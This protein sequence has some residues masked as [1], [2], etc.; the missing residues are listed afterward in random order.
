MKGEKIKMKDVMLTTID[1]PFDPFKEFDD[2]LTYDESM[3]YFTC[4]YLGRIGKTSH[5]LSETDEK[6]AIEYAIDEI[7]K[8]NLLGIYKKVFS[9]VE[10]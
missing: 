5:E 4:N 1:N 2:W 10:E 7:I 6:Q 9:E 8:L 3:G